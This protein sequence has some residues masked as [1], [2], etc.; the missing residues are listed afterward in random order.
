MQFSTFTRPHWSDFPVFTF[1]DWVE[2]RWSSLVIEEVDS[3][4][5]QEFLMCGWKYPNQLAVSNLDE[6]IFLVI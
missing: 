5:S 6:A 2:D 4:N 1:I 3:V